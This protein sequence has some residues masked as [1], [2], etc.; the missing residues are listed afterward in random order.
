VTQCSPSFMFG[1]FS[2][3]IAVLS[4]GASASPNVGSAQYETFDSHF[5]DIDL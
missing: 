4:R 5:C 3:S 1:D 2:D